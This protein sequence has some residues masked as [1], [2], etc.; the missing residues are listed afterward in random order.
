[1]VKEA[2]LEP[3]DL[4]HQNMSCNLVGLE[5]YNMHINYAPV[6]TLLYFTARSAKVAYAGHRKVTQYGSRIVYCHLPVTNCVPFRLF[7]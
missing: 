2:S 6:I 7:S 3:E 4:F 1:M 5:H